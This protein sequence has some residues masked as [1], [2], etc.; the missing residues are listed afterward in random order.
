MTHRFRALPLLTLLLAASCSAANALGSAGG[1]PAGTIITNQAT[2]DYIDDNGQTQSLPSNIVTSTVQQVAGVLITPNGDHTTPG[3]IV[4]TK[5][6]T[7]GVLTYTL[8]NTGNGPDTYLLTVVDPSANVTAAQ[9]I[10]TEDTNNSGALD[11]GD[12]VVTNASTISLAADATEKIFVSYPVAAGTPGGTVFDMALQGTSNFDASIVDQNNV[13]RLTTQGDLS[14]TLTPSNTGTVTSPGTVSYAHTLTNT[15]NAPLTNSNVNGSLTSPSTA[16]GWT[17]LYSYNGNTYADLPSLLAAAG[18]IPQGGKLDFAVK[19]TAPAGVPRTT[20]SVGTLSAYVTTASDATTNNLTPQASQQTVTDT[21][22][23]RQG[24][25][26]IGKTQSLGTLNASTGAVTFGPDV[27]TDLAPRPCDVLRYTITNTNQGDSALIAS[28][29]SDVL[30][31]NLTPLKVVVSNGVL[32]KAGAVWQA[33]APAYGIGAA[34]T[35]GLDSN[36][37]STINTTDVL[38][39]GNTYTLTI[40]GQVKRAGDTCTVPVLP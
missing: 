15:G 1:V 13:G 19:V 29:V 37:D 16:S 32:F 20:V 18:A 12:Q 30:N 33:T 26:S 4:P 27:T 14:L 22:T 28:T 36:A 9:A 5:Q 24:I 34:I 11:A 6:G 35:V 31:S 3:Q 7:T 10:I 21:T 23:V 25:P 38:A 40:Y 39:P 2:T 8:T 17:Y